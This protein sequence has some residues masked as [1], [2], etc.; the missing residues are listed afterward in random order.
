MAI[1]S[2]KNRFQ[3]L[4]LGKRNALKNS[5]NENIQNL[6][7]DTSKMNVRADSLLVSTNGVS[8][9]RLLAETQSGGAFQH[10]SG[11]PYQGKA[12]K[13]VTENIPRKS[14]S[15]WSCMTESLPGFLFNFVR[16]AMQ[17]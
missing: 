13:I 2:I 8:A 5:P 3:R 15:L 12:I 9:Q 7:V 17:S 4:Q 10:L 11:L 14:I 6:W 16:K 1:P